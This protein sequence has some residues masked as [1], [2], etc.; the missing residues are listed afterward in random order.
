MAS[1]FIKRLRYE[2][3]NYFYESPLLSNGL[4]IILGNN[5]NGKSTFTYLISYILGNSIPY[6]KKDNRDPIKEI[7]NDTDNFVELE[8]DINDVTY[9]FKRE[10]G[11]NFITIKDKENSN[12]SILSI[13][14]NGTIYDLSKKTFS[15]WL[16]YKLGIDSIEINQFNTTHKINF[17]DFFRLVYLDQRTESSNIYTEVEGNNFFKKS[18]LVKKTI[19]ETLIGQYFKDYYDTYFKLKDLHVK[20][21]GIVAN[22]ASINRLKEDYKVSFSIENDVDLD[23]KIKIIQLNLDNYYKKREELKKERNNFEVLSNHLTK[24]ENDLS[25]LNEEY[26]KLKNKK[27]ETAI[28]LINLHKALETANEEIKNISKILYTSERLSLLNT[29]YCPLCDSESDE[30]GSKLSRLD[31]FIY[32]KIEYDT[33]LKTK[34]KLLNTIENSINYCESSMIKIDTELKENRKLY[35]EYKGKFSN[36]I[37]E[38]RFN[39]NTSILNEIEENIYFYSSQLKNLE[40]ISKFNKNLEQENKDLNELEKKISKLMTKYN[41]LE[42]TKEITLSKNL[43]TFTKIYEDYMKDIYED[44]SSIHINK[45][46]MPIIN[47]GEYRESSFDI[48]KRFFYYLSLLKLANAEEINFPNLLIIDTLSNKGLEHDKIIKCYQCLKELSLSTNQ[49]ILTSGYDEYDSKFDNYVIERLSNENK[50]LKRRNF[51]LL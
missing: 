30:I 4:N 39:F 9:F 18:L 33:I 48:P 31:S 21:E 2:G 17:D 1:L 19:F 42:E 49:I 27:K 14:R 29:N 12:I 45:E 36:L 6:F 20:S 44:I 51:L 41:E 15:D 26:V 32:T 7:V 23:E 38:N 50:L 8:I 46:Y 16:L 43:N 10:I 37:I 35:E 47:N 3:Q 40:I 13:E 25:R 24:I 5:G 34:I 28:D 22:I 11:K